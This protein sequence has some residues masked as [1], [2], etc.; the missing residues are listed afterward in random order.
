MDFRANFSFA[1]FQ[2]FNIQASAIRSCFDFNFEYSTH[3]HCEF[4]HFIM[5]DLTLRLCY[6][7]RRLARQ[8]S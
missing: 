5:S 3:V 1:V 8:L 2:N 4:K 7:L 6:E